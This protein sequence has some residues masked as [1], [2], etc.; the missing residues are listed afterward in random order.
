MR[1]IVFLACLFF[2]ALFAQEF[3][4]LLPLYPD[5]KI[6]LSKENKNYLESEA[7]LAKE[8]A[9]AE[10]IFATR[11]AFYRAVF[12]LLFIPFLA[13]GFLWLFVEYHVE[14]RLSTW[15]NPKRDVI[16]D[17]IAKINHPETKDDEK[18][19]LL[20]LLARAKISQGEGIDCMHMANPD[21][22]EHVK[23]SRAIPLPLKQ[24]L[25]SLISKLDLHC[26]AS[27]P[28]NE[29]EWQRDKNFLIDI[30]LP[31]IHSADKTREEL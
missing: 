18:W 27:L 11:Q 29:E 8:Q 16:L 30:N 13:F 4:P 19:A 6:T 9:R 21:L 7:Y 3:L 20:S 15:L 26:F 10:H 1:V 14:K 22:K 12:L 5:S 24:P 28:H 2:G 31:N 17:L 25:E 23:A